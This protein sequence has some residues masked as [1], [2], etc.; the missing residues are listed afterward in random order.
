MQQSG[1]TAAISKKDLL[2]TGLSATNKVYDATTAAQLSG[3][4]GV[5]AISGD[6]VTVGGTALGAFGDKNVGTGKSVT[7]TGVTIGGTDAGNYN[8]VQQS[9][10]SADISIRPLSTW[11]G[12]TAGLWSDA[13]NWD[14]LPSGANVATVAI[15][16]GTGAVTYDA[17]AGNTQLQSL[18]NAQSLSVNGGSLAVSGDTTVASGAN[19]S[20]NA[21][22]FSTAS[23]LNQGLVNGSGPLVLNG[24]Y[25]ESG[26]SLGTGFSRVSITQTSGDLSLKG[27]GATGPITLASS[28]GGLNLSGTVRSGAAPIDLNASGALGLQ[29]A[30]VDASGGLAG[31]TVQLDGSSISVANS[32]VTTSGLNDG[33]A[34]RVGLRTLPS[35]VS[36]TNSTLVADPPGLGGSITID[37]RSIA[38]AGSTFNVFGLSGGSITL[39]SA[40]TSGISLDA[41]SSLIGG[42]GASFG[43]FANSILNNASIV[44][45]TLFVNGQPALASSAPVPSIVSFQSSI[46][47]I[48]PNLINNTVDYTAPGSPLTVQWEQMGIDPLAISLTESAFLYANSFLSS[49]PQLLSVWDVSTPELFTSLLQQGTPLYSVR[50]TIDPSVELK[51]ISPLQT[52]AL[53]YRSF[54]QADTAAAAAFP[55]PEPLFIP[56]TTFAGAWPSGAQVSLSLTGMGVF[57]QAVQQLSTQQVASQFNAAEQKSMEETVTKLGLDPTSG[58]AVP[59][60]VELQ[61][62]LRQVIEAVRRRVRGGAP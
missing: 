42:G 37:G 26:G 32:T 18:F 31:G 25:T 27:V 8:L 16:V 33:G 28:A 58:R 53:V 23:L 56:S 51:P 40:S 44:G 50:L 36:I 46:D 15:P 39:G 30:T 49:D 5:S 38:I 48:Q 47:P 4:A 61:S 59:T 10:L 55:N 7:V 45:G 17:A 13:A 52:D 60:P 9:G 22:A 54:M 14:A 20:I 34:I 3:S 43:L 24:I 62:S 35:S 6:V 57:D 19:L 29:G 1:L 2:A 21:G 12:S 11:R 41:F